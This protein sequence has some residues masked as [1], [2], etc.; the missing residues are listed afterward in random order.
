MFCLIYTVYIIR[1]H[2]STIVV[3]HHG[4]NPVANKQTCHEISKSR[5][6]KAWRCTCAKRKEMNQKK[7][8]ERERER[9]REEEKR[10]ERDGK[11][12]GLV[13]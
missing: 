7:E 2:E 11:Q 10:R 8:Q 9:E 1:E 3:F 13:G 6:A 4:L 12:E 5:G